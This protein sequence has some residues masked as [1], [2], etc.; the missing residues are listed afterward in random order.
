M[1][2]AKKKLPQQVISDPEARELLEWAGVT[3]QSQS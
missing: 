3:R 1:A 2:M